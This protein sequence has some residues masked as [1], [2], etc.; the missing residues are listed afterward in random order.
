MAK[1]GTIVRYTAKQLDALR[2]RGK[3]RT[4][5]AKLTR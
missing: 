1:T 2:H 3:S 5:W 4:N